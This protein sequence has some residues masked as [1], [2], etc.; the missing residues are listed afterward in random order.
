MVPDLCG[1]AHERVLACGPI[2]ATSCV[3]NHRF[4]VGDDASL[5]G[6]LACALGLRPCPVFSLA[7]EGIGWCATTIFTGWL[8]GRQR[9]APA[10]AETSRMPAL[11]FDDP[12]LYR[13][14][15]RY[16]ECGVPRYGNSFRVSV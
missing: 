1:I 4:E 7:T 15:F 3:Y 5:S 8:H 10:P 16:F 14:M 11:A 6:I 2:C 9:T 12:H 13:F